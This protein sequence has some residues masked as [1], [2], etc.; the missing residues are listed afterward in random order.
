VQYYA[1]NNTQQ[2]HAQKKAATTT[3][4]IITMS[5]RAFFEPSTQT[6]L[7][8][9]A[10]DLRASLFTGIYVRDRDEAVFVLAGL[11]LNMEDDQQ[12]ACALS[13]CT[14][15]DASR[16]LRIYNPTAIEPSAQLY[17]VMASEFLTSFWQQR[18]VMNDNAIAL[19]HAIQSL[20]RVELGSYNNTD[21]AIYTSVITLD[22]SSN[23]H[24]ANR[25]VFTTVFDNT[26][27]NVIQEIIHG[28]SLMVADACNH[29]L[30]QLSSGSSDWNASNIYK[31]FYVECLAGVTN[32]VRTWSR[33]IGAALD[34]DA[35]ASS[36]MSNFTANTK[37]IV[38]Q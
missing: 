16:R 1:C 7:L 18:M 2:A 3:T 30:Q 25:G 29:S 5:V 11:I 20:K 37:M 31:A 14:S 28:R 24:I 6:L 4:T 38:L 33:I 32:F 9:S 21:N 35:S 36:Q 8:A 26:K 12:V 22:A 27:H 34:T 17:Y 13:F 19:S 15:T 10:T 23:T